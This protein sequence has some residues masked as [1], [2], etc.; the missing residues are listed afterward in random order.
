M[1]P[2]Q[3]EEQAEFKE[4]PQLN[5]KQRWQIIQVLFKNDEKGS[6]PQVRVKSKSETKS[7]VNWQIASE[8][9]LGDKHAV[10]AGD[11]NDTFTEVYYKKGIY[12]H[13]DAT[14]KD[15]RNAFID[16]NQLDAEDRMFCFLNSDVPR[17]Y[18]VIDTEDEVMLSQI[19]HNL[20]QPRT[21]YI[22]CR[23]PG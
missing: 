13:P 18:I 12:L 4:P 20:V 5:G 11:D 15:L 14:L 6:R 7:K 16:S 3:K 9:G 8:E 19:E 21:L 23:D 10:S 17:D 1:F 2:K 22:E